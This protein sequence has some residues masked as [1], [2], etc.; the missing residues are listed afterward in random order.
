MKRAFSARR[1]AR[2]AARMGVLV[3]AAFVLSWIEFLL[4]LPVGIPGVKLGLCHI[5]V[6]FCLYRL[7]PGE[8]AAV[9]LV[10]A[11]LAF[12]LFGTAVSLIY[13]LAGAVLSLAVMLLLKRTGVFS[14][15]AVSVSGAVTHNLTQLGCAALLMRTA[16]L[17]FYAPVLRTAALL[18]GAAVGAAG[19]LC[20]RLVPER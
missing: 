5:V 13:S 12:L 10:R 18:T 8:A 15:A 3:A 2:F 6:L 4:P 7:T 11:L 19:S 20:I 14:P 17:A 1:A 16:G 9:S